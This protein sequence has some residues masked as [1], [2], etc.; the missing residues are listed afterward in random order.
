[1]VAESDADANLDRALIR[2]LTER[3]DD[4]TVCPSEVATRSRS[5]TSGR[6]AVRPAFNASTDVS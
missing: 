5:V 3:G 4:K 6:S 1:V 2:L